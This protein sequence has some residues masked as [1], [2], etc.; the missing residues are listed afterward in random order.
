MNILIRISRF[1]V[2]SFAQSYLIAIRP[3]GWAPTL[4]ATTF[5]LIDGGFND[6]LTIVLCLL[7]F[8]PLLAG[9]A[10]VLNFLADAEDDK[11]SEV[12]KDIVMAHQP[13]STGAL[14][15]RQGV[16]MAVLHGI[17]GLTALGL[18]GVG[19]LLVGVAVIL[20]GTVYSLPPRLKRLPLMDVA[21]NGSIV[22]L[23]YIGGRLTQAGLRPSAALPA[24]W[25]FFLV[26]ATYLLTEIIDHS[27]DA[28]S[29]VLTTAVLLGIERTVR[30]SCVLYA[31][32]F[33]L[34]VAAA[35]G[36]RKLNY[37]VIAPGIVWALASFAKRILYPEK[38]D[39]S[40]LAKRATVSA[41]LSTIL[42]I[43]MY[44]ILRTL[45]VQSP[46]I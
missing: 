42:L 7:A 14:S 43:S 5:G 17:C 13:F 1:R 15:V 10:Y 3:V 22:S 16:V 34:F 25:I 37:F 4:F 27:A 31:L 6:S 8:G 23:C 36:E 20:L 2:F 11:R 21:S 40:R 26:S 28:R 30:F 18:L 39:M 44:I 19:P 32:S 24:L 41:V 45:G 9:S 46:V 33:L 35:S 29:G 12:K 38:W